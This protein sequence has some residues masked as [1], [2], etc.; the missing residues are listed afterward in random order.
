MSN[1]DSKVQAVLN[2]AVRLQLMAWKRQLQLKTGHHGVMLV[3]LMMKSN[4]RRALTVELMMRP[5][6]RKK[7]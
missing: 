3:K 6:L 5:R 4:L 1:E 7:R 2:Q